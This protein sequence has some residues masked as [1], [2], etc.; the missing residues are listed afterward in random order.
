MSPTL[1]AALY[2]IQRAQMRLN[3]AASNVAR[4]SVP[5][6]RAVEVSGDQLVLSEAGIDLSRELVGMN[7]AKIQLQ[8]SV[9]VARQDAETTKSLLD[10]VG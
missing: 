9:K 7:V 1:V 3:A 5:N 8:A 10:L 6:A 2:G 4:I